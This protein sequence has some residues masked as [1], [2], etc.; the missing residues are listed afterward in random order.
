MS[1][2]RTLGCRSRASV[3]VALGVLAGCT[4]GSV[5]EEGGEAVPEVAEIAAAEVPQDA[6]VATLRRF[7][8]DEMRRS[9]RAETFPHEAHVQIDCAIC[10][11]VA[12]GHGSHDTVECADCHRASALATVRALAAADCQACHHGADQ[13]WTCEH[14]HGAPGSYR[15]TQ[16]LFLA[17]WS[18]PRSR[19]L[20]FEHAWHDGL[21]CAS[22]HASR[23]SLSPEPCAACHED[24]H[25]ATVRCQSCHTPPREGAHD[26][27]AHLTCGGAGCHRAPRVEAIAGSRSACLV[28]HQAQEDHEP[29]GECIECHRVRPGT[30]GSLDP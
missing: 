3:L 30:V 28:C 22:C 12:E 14:C 13:S 25:V 24:H 4:G 11:Q 17:V 29:G 16:E 5:P 26:V 19:E 8:P 6:A 1:A 9:T 7:L 21:D 23:P 20:A 15:T 10:H 2:W 27:D 18:A